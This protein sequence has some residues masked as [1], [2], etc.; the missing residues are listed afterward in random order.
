MPRLI[1][2]SPDGMPSPTANGTGPE[3]P[4]NV[5]KQS[6]TMNSDNI[7][8]MSPSGIAPELTQLVAAPA[9]E[10]TIHVH[11][12]VLPPGPARSG[13]AAASRAH[14]NLRERRR[15]GRRRAEN[16]RFIV[17]VKADGCWL[18]G[19]R[20]LLRGDLHFHHL[21][22][23]QKKGCVARLVNRSTQAVVE[24]IRKTRLICVQCHAEHHAVLESE[25]WRTG[26]CYDL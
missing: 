19:N 10:L 12:H 17:K 9:T 2:L 8:T 20:S 7:R 15:K 1:R 23:R 21:D 25:T 11:H 4:K 18:C 16:R 14:R 3:K 5:L 22:P 13:T 6:D 26:G 24:E